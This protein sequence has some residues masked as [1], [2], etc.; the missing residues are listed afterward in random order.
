MIFNIYNY[1]V[2]TDTIQRTISYIQRNSQQLQNSTTP[3]EDKKGYQFVALPTIGADDVYDVDEGE[4]VEA[5]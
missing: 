3:G 4:S 2:T 1:C 5:A